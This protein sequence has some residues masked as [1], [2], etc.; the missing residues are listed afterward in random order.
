MFKELIISIGAFFKAYSFITKKNVV[1]WILIPGILYSLVFIF[2]IY[3]FLHTYN[4]FIEWMIL[5][6]GLK[7]ILDNLNSS[8]IGFL[9]T[10]STF[11]ISFFLMLYYFSLFKFIYYIIFSPLYIIFSYTFM[12]EANQQKQPLTFAK[13]LTQFNKIALLNLRLCLGQTIYLFFLMFISLIP[14][15]GWFIPILI[16]LLECYYMG[17]IMFNFSFAR[18]N[19]SY[20]STKTYLDHYKGLS[21]GNGI[22]YYFLH[23]I[24]IIGW[25]FA[26]YYALVASKISIELFKEN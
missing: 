10:M 13:F 9:V 5:K 25:I 7:T 15:I 17:A 22:I 18:I 3:F 11:N 21:M 8:V 19:N 2:S 26:P 4:N 24:P 6:T 14:I 23:F 20:H 1:K 12:Y 16:L